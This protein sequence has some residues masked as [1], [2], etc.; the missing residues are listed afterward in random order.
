M[1]SNMIFTEERARE[2]KK[3]F[4][5]MDVNND[6]VLTRSELK[7]L[8]VGIGEQFREEDIDALLEMAD[9]DDNGLIDFNE[10]VVSA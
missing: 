5:I 3:D 6:G 8:I 9:E 10:F 4:N 7:T 1:N 2:L